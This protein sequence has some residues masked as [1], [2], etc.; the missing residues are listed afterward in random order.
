MTSP[1]NIAIIKKYMYESTENM[2]KVY[3][4]IGEKL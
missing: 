2:I 3:K 4:F 1:I